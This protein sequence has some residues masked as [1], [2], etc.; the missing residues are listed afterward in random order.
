ML[1]T[2][3]KIN[4]LQTP[5]SMP[6]PCPIAISTVFFLCFMC[7][8]KMAGN[9][10]VPFRLLSSSNIVSSVP[11]PLG[12]LQRRSQWIQFLSFYFSTSANISCSHLGCQLFPYLNFHKAYYS[13]E[14][15]YTQE[16]LRAREVAKNAR[17]SLG[18]SEFS[19]QNPHWATPMPSL[20]LWGYMHI[21]IYT[22][23]YT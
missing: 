11:I 16:V 23:S 12:L 9:A 19:S 7:G 10:N 22:H 13:P 4:V 20:D 17:C 14:I 3:P 1:L 8:L 5:F 15:E 6:W 21:V 2:A 18:G